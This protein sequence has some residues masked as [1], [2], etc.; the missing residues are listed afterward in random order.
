MEYFPCVSLKMHIWAWPNHSRFCGSLLAYLLTRPL[1]S[2]AERPPWCWTSCQ[3]FT[4]YRLWLGWIINIVNLV[5]LSFCFLLIIFDSFGFLYEKLF[6]LSELG[7][8]SIWDY[9]SGKL[10][11]THWRA[12]GLGI[13]Q[14]TTIK[15]LLHCRTKIGPGVKIRI[16]NFRPHFDLV[17]FFI[18]STTLIWRGILFIFVQ[19]IIH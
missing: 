5:I 15:Y 10:S 12:A 18:C 7:N 8:L 13:A 16:Q 17:K 3:L 6:Q 11:A 1:C 9:W 4:T 2:A 19:L 14:G